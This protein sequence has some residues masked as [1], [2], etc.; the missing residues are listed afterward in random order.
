MLASS[1]LPRCASWIGTLAVRSL[2][3]KIWSPGTPARLPIA[4]STGVVVIS[5]A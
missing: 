1:S 3:P 5:R 4:V 2:T